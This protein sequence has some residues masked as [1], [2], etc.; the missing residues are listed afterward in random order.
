MDMSVFD[1]IAEAPLPAAV[2]EP[3]LQS[4]EWYI[5]L[6]TLC[7]MMDEVGGIDV[8]HI[9]PG[10]A[11]P[12]DWDK[13]AFKGGS[14]IGVLNLTTRAIGKDGSDYCVAATWNDDA[15]L[16]E[17]ALGSAYSALLSALSRE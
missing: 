4:V 3:H 14:E 11:Q 13:V 17:A 16:N 6:T 15:A 7:A 8:M 2:T 5:P 10:V 1:D 9:N 12:G